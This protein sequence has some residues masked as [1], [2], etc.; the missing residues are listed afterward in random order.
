MCNIIILEP[1][2]MPIR[3][4]FDTMCWNNWHAFGL[5]TLIDG[6]L[7]ITK[8]AFTECDEMKPQV[9][10]DLLHRDI[11]FRR[12]LHVRHMTAGNNNVENAHPFDVFYSDK[13][14]VQFMHNGTLYNY[15]SK[16]KSESGV[17]SDDDTG[18][19][20]SKNFVDQVLT[21]YLSAMDFGNGHGDIRHPMFLKLLD[22]FWTS[23]N[24]NRGLL[25]SSDQGYITVGTWKTRKDS[26]GGEFLTAN[27]DY[28][29]VVSRGP[30]AKRREESRKALE[31]SK[32]SGNKAA[33]TS[34]ALVPVTPLSAFP[35][36]G[37]PI[38]GFFTV[39]DS[40]KNILQD[41]SLYDREHAVTV[42]A[43]TK[44]ELLEIMKNPEDAIFLM[45]LIF[46]DYAQ[47]Y[48]DLLET[49]AKHV[50]ASKLIAQLQAQLSPSKKEAA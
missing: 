45:D 37:K 18:P 28:F 25:I 19:S 23:G 30:E 11:M 4:E 36:L 14:T 34:T 20:D 16:K 1:G 50:R 29:T 21:P 38:Y 13:R 33:N 47:M 15:K 44:E 39:K 2:Q 22:Q 9:I 7:D 31:S 24:T 10:W 35:N 27:D 12:I 6:K 42:G 48:E 40:F 32:K 26:A 49:E 41:W 43:L 17:V 3:D 46:T 8:K 5:V